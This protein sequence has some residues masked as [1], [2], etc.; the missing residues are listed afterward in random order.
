MLTQFDFESAGLGL[1][2]DFAP[3]KGIVDRAFK[4]FAIANFEDCLKRRRRS[5]PSLLSTGVKVPI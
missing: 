3:G 2:F 1:D 4:R 5:V